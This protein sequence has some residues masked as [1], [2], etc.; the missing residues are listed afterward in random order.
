MYKFLRTYLPKTL[1]NILIALWY[2]LLIVFNVYC[3][4]SAT[5]GAF[6]YVGW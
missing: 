3:G 5:Q 2:F 1:A 6:Q 4:I